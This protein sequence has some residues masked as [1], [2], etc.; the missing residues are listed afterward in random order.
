M[1]VKLDENLSNTHAEFLRQAGYDCDRVTDEELS[2]A[3]DDRIWQRVC[4]ENRFFITLDLYFSDIR[5]F[6]PGT[7]PGILLLRPSNRSRQAVLELLDRLLSEQRLEN[8]QGCLV[9]A[10]ERQTRVRCP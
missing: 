2:G 1:L 5:K 9:V 7:H 10:D 3:E 6:S 4:T 8:W